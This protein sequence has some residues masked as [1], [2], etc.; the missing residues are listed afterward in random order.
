[1]TSRPRAGLRPTREQVVD[2]LH[3]GDFLLGSCTLDELVYV[4]GVGD[5]GAGPLQ[6]FLDDPTATD[7]LVYGPADIWGDRGSVLVR[8]DL[9]ADQDVRDLDVRLG[10]AGGKRLDDFSPRVDT[11]LPHGARRLASPRLASLCPAGVVI[12]LPTLRAQA[13]TLDELAE[14]QTV[15]P[16]WVPVSP[17]G[18]P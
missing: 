13:F 12:S 9:G 1:M 4:A 11:H 7:G 15:Q 2:A 14:A 17:A 18:D 16:G 6:I 5:S 8:V 3:A 10:A